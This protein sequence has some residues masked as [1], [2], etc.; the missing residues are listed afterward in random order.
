MLAV[1]YTMT[2]IFD[3]SSS[4]PKAPAIRGASW[5]RWEVPCRRSRTLRR[6]AVVIKRRMTISTLG[7]QRG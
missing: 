2:G 7:P 5:S 6:D 4:R 3:Y 1:G